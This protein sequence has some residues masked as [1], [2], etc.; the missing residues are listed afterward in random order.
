M[1]IQYLSSK[2]LCL[3]N[4][5]VL[6]LYYLN[7]TPDNW[8]RCEAAFIGHNSIF[9]QDIVQCLVIMVRLDQMLLY[10]M[11]YHLFYLKYYLAMPNDIWEMVWVGIDISRY[12]FWFLVRLVSSQDFTNY[13]HVQSVLYVHQNLC[14]ALIPCVKI[15]WICQSLT[16][17]II[18]I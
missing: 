13:M 15:T 7:F 11:K 18:M 6:R 5:W 9:L 14:T 10:L 16:Q 4:A 3:P 12:M 2:G 8:V 17:T 1:F